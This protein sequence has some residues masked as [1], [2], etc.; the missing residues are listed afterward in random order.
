[1]TFSPFPLFCFSVLC[2]QKKRVEWRERFLDNDP[3]VRKSSVVWVVK[4][5][6]VPFRGKTGENQLHMHSPM[7]LNSQAYTCPET[8]TRKQKIT[9]HKCLTVAPKHSF[10]RSRTSSNSSAPTIATIQSHIRTSPSSNSPASLQLKIL[11]WVTLTAH[12]TDSSLKCATDVH[13]VQTWPHPLSCGG[14]LYLFI[15]KQKQIEI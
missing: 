9:L 7:P 14:S 2:R 4:I 8:G 3:K 6:T 10:D 11:K 1:M 15:R 13:V 12:A 5:Y